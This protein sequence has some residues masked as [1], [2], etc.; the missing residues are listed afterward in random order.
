MTPWLL[1]LLVLAAVSPLAGRQASHPLN[2]PTAEDISRVVASIRSDSRTPKNLIFISAGIDEPSKADYLAFRRGERTLQAGIRCI[3]Y[4]QQSR[5][6]YE[7]AGE[8]KTGAITEFKRLDGVQP[9]LTVDDMDSAAAIALKH[10]GVRSALQRR[11]IPVDSIIVETWASGVPFSSF[12]TRLVRC[13]FFMRSNGEHRYDRPV[14]GLHVLINLTKKTVMEIHDRP[15][16]PVAR[17]EPWPLPI[18]KKR[19]CCNG[20]IRVYHGSN[21]I[22]ELFQHHVKGLFYMMLNGAME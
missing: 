16:S 22:F 12:N 14:E 10:T 5:T 6:L 9:W 3:G 11:S 7:I 15:Q 17:M 1:C 4:D 21:G 2:N 13:I 18:S 20:L 8:A 19:R